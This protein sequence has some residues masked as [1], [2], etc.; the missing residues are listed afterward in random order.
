MGLCAAGVPFDNYCGGENSTARSFPFSSP[1][2]RAVSTTTPP[3]PVGWQLIHSSSFRILASFETL[4]E[5][6]KTSELHRASPIVV[7]RART[8]LRGEEDE[9]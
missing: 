5:R 8:H 1:L 4:V 2:C 7:S 3:D 6:P 9:E